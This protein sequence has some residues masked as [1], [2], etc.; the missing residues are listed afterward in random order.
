MRNDFERI[1][2]RSRLAD[3]VW[4]DFWRRFGLGPNRVVEIN[5]W[6]ADIAQARGLTVQDVEDAWEHN[7]H[8]AAAGWRFERVNAVRDVNGNRARL[9]IRATKEA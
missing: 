1:K 4:S 3:A 7:P 5:V 9:T 6:A 8:A 2:E